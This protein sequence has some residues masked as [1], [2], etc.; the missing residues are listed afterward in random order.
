MLSPII[1]DCYATGVL[2]EVRHPT[3]IHFF[4][5]CN[6]AV[7]REALAE[8][9]F[10]DEGCTA[11]EDVDMCKRVANR[12]WRLFYEPAAACFHEPRRSLWALMR[13]WFWYGRGAARVFH[14][15][16]AARFELFVS[17]DP[18][19]RIF[20]YRR[21]VG[22]RRFPVRGL[23]FVNYFTLLALLLFAL[24]AAL[25][26]AA[27]VGASILVGLLAATLLGMHARNPV[28][29]GRSLREILVYYTVGTAMNVA[30][31]AG[32]LVGGLRRGMLYLHPGV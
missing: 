16:Q 24:V 9:G 17:L 13:Q 30:C 23:L 8:A 31:T 2:P 28:L 15:H 32:G 29:A 21:W 25:V 5:N 1:T 7:R 22:A 4:P 3:L 27:W 14:K 6:L 19:P 11:S 10:Y 18:R 12:G 26:C 20:S